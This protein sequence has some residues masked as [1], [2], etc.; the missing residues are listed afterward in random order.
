[1]KKVLVLGAAGQI[2]RWVISMLAN[3]AD[4]QLTLYLR[5]VGKL[6][7]SK[8]KNAQIVQRCRPTA[9]I[10][11]SITELAP[12]ARASRSFVM[13]G[14]AIRSANSNADSRTAPASHPCLYRR[15]IES[16]SRFLAWK[17]NPVRPRNT[18]FT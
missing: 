4:I 9:F 15:R 2:A 10:A 5:H 7:A 6:G 18:R 13:S 16:L 17:A 12:V 14:S 1:M 3:N 8:P 11:P